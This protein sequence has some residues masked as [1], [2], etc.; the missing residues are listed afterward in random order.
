MVQIVW[1]RRALADL[2]AIWAYIGQFSPLAAQRMTLK[3]R[4][5][6]LGLHEHPERGRAV[7]CGQACGN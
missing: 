7:R 5:A 6:A 3:L 4:A 1:S 2:S